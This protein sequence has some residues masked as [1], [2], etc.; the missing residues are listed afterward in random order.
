MSIIPTEAAL[1]LPEF[2]PVFTQ[3]TYRRFMILLLG[4]ILTTGRRTVAN[5]LRTVGDVAHGAPSSFHRVLS[6]T[7]WSGLQLACVLARFIVRHFYPEGVI[8]LAGDDTVDEHRGKKVYGKSRHRDAVRSSHSYTAHRYGHKWVVLAILV[9]FPFATR[10]WA[11]PVL[12]TLY[13]SPK[14]NKA[15]GRQHKTPVELMRLML[16]LLLRWFPD[17]QFQFAGD[18]GFG[19]HQLARFA[20][21]SHGRLTLVSRFYAAANLYDPPPQRKNKK[22]GRPRLKGAKKPAPQDVVAKK[23]QPRQRL[24]VAWYGGV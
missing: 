18:G 13:R 10:Y 19:T 15:R 24:T 21:Q 20:H 17:R 11:L 6:S 9:K 7:R 23:Q 16:R 5:V 3:P 1:L 22:G 8:L 14:D 4:T 12:V 2:A